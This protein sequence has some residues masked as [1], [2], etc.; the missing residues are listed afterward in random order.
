MSPID[1][2]T[3]P[4][5]IALLL[6]GELIACATGG[7]SDDGVYQVARREL[8][9][10]PNAK[11]LLPKFVSAHRTLDSFWGWIKYEAGT[12]AERRT[13][14]YSAFSPLLDELERNSSS[15]ADKD[16]SELLEKPSVQSISTAWSKALER[17]T[18]DPEGAITSARTLLE[19]VCKTILDERDIE[20][21]DK[22]D[23]PKLYGKVSGAL[24]LAPDKHS[25]EIFKTILGGCR[26]VVVGLGSLRNRLSD[27]HGKGTQQVR[28]TDRHAALAVNL[29]GAMA[30]FLL[31]THFKVQAACGSEA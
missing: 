26:S 15:P 6:Q 28:P 20:Y 9:D 21:T 18:S 19:S 27:A 23:L 24:N 1:S 4:V 13:I 11:G 31:E 10:L 22:D 29:S 17:R 25:E 7:R 16:I 30:M 14:I 8:M 5:D 12:Y 2:S 3:S